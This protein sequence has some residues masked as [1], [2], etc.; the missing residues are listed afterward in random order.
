MLIFI[1]LIGENN[2]QIFDNFFNDKSWTNPITY[3]TGNRSR[4]KKTHNYYMQPAV[5][6]S[7]YKTIDKREYCQLYK[8]ILNTH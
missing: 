4:S 8:S 1:D 7:V 5:T 6:K 3:L 2:S